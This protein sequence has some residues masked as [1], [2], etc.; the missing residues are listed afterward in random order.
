MSSGERKG[1]RASEREPGDL[2]FVLISVALYPQVSQLTIPG[3]RFFF[4]PLYYEE[5]GT[6]ITEFPSISK[7]PTQ[8]YSSQHF[9]R[10]LNKSIHWEQNA[11]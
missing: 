9:Q 4:F 5:N 11:I 3:S 8:S 2:I 6:D 1:Q 7:N 10:S